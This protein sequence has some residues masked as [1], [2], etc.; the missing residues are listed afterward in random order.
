MLWKKSYPIGAAR[1]IERFHQTEPIREEEL[2]SLQSYLLHN[3]KDLHQALLQFPCATLIGSAGSFETLVEVLN[4]DLKRGITP[5]GKYADNI[6]LDAFFEFVRLITSLDKTERAKL[7]GMSDFRV[8]MI[9]VAAILMDVVV[10][11][12]AITTLIASRYSLKE[13]ILFS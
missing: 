7:N 9:V 2:V 8:E 13:G 12:F 4:K 10:K 6:E 5:L 1:L 11:R 3:M